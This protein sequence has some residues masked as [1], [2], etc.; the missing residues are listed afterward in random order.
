MGGI[1][2]AALNAHT[3]IAMDIGDVN[4]INNK[5]TYNKYT[6]TYKF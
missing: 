4:C 1:D 2:I 5:E 6:D 3:W